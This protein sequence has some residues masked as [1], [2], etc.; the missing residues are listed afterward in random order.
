MNINVPMAK[1]IRII[2]YILLIFIGI[3]IFIGIWLNFYFNKKI[4]ENI[5]EQISESTHGEYVF[6]LDELTINIL[7]HT[8]TLNNPGIGPSQQNIMHSKAQYV[9]KAK[10]LRIIDF[11]I[12]SYLKEKALLIDRIEFEEPQISIFQGYE[13]LPKKKINPSS[14]KLSLY[15]AFSKKLNSI[16]IAHIDIMNSKFNIYKNGTDT[17]S[18]FSTNDNSIS[19]NNFYVNSETDKKNRLFI[20]EKFEIVM[21]KFSYHLGNGL[22]MI[23]GKSLYASYFDSTLIVDSLQLVP[24]YSKKDFADEAGSQVSRAKVIS[25]KVTCKKMDVKLFFEYNWLVIH[26]VDVTGCAIDVF[27]DN[28]LPLAPIHRPSLQAMVKSLPFFVEVD[29]IELKNGTVNFEVL[30]PGATST[31]KLSVNKFNIIITG[32]QNDTSRY[33]GDENIKAIVNGSIMNQGKFNETYTFPL[34]STKEFFYC[35]GSMSGMPMN[36][37]NPIFEQAKHISIKSG[38]IDHVSFSFIAHENSSNGTMIFKYHDLKVEML[39]KEDNKNNLQTKLKTFLAN[40]LVIHDSNPGKD[41]IVR[42]SNIYAKHNPYRYFLNYSMQ[43]VLSGIEPAIES[44]KGAKMLQK[45]K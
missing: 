34:K 19:I 38:Q 23:Y 30:N 5:K 22:Y 20:A 41:G 4:I 35:S 1:V 17:L 6:S 42:I 21:N 27:R 43:S 29:T 36:S 39:N 32:V 44:E 40:K 24:N 45:R 37:F 26:K 7:T 15:S 33:L 28:T 8:I 11:S 13:R 2:S 12:M 25:S 31:G 9:F 10:V 14:A 18:I 16:S 3:F